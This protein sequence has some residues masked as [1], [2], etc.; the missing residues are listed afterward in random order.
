MTYTTSSPEA[1]LVQGPDQILQMAIG[2]WI[3]KTL[4]T[5]LELGVFEA[6]VGPLT[7]EELADQLN[8]PVASLQSLLTAL[9]ALGL[10]EHKA[11]NWGNSLLTET[12]LVKHSPKYL[13]GPYEYFNQVYELWRYLPSAV[14]EGTT[15]WLEAFGS[16][17]GHNAFEAWYTDPLK[18]KQ[19]LETM[20]ASVRSYI[21]ELIE[22]FDFS[23]FRHLLDV[24]GALGDLP[25]AILQRY[26]RLHA[27]VFELPQVKPLAVENIQKHG[28]SAR[29]DVVTGDFFEEDL[30]DGADLITLSYI[31]HDWTDEQCLRILQRCFSALHSGGQILI[32]EKALNEERTGPL[33]PALMN[34]NMLVATGGHERPMSEYSNMLI[35]AGFAHPRLTQLNDTRD[36]ISAKKL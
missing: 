9:A 12:Y 21:H 22:Y 25:I 20:T 7:S 23:P 4:F 24:G 15:R 6:L 1:S 8:L 36:M 31:L 35:A 2:F 11:K 17:A 33:Y 18:L 29:I 10:L 19:Y 32:L 27:T 3:S 30:P 28:M 13:G 34:L 5:G 14:R 26:P 16:Q